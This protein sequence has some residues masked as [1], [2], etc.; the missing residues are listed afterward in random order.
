M[1]DLN[2]HY[3]SDA[4]LQ[5]IS[6]QQTISN[7]P[8]DWA[9]ELPTHDYSQLPDVSEQLLFSW[10]APERV[11]RPRLSK[12]YQRN[13]IL[14]F[15]LIGLL[16]IAAN[17]FTLLIVILALIFLSF[18]MAN[19][20]PQKI[21][22][23]ITNYGIYTNRKFYPWLQRGKRFWFETSRDQKQLI[24]E[25]QIFPYRIVMLVGHPRNQAH[26]EKILSRYLIQQQPPPTSIDKIAIWLEQH[27]AG[28]EQPPTAAPQAS[29]SPI[30]IN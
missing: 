14:L 25:T 15:I 21:R 5:E 23:T 22:H 24:F 13:L 17:Q 10:V 3:L 29:T 8:T 2:Q 30:S 27:F 20:P 28:D 1:P 11:F 19:V 12:N 4:Q 16:L 7:Q 9:Q 18:V 6:D 26:L